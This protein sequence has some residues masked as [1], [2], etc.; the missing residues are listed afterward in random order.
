MQFKGVRAFSFYGNWIKKR[1]QPLSLG[2]AYRQAL[3]QERTE[4]ERGVA[5]RLC[6][7]MDKERR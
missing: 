2:W 5:I 7:A 4:E 6:Q 1:N 3:Q